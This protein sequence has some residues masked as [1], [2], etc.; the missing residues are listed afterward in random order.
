M[1]NRLDE[2]TWTWSKSKSK[3]EAE[4]AGSETDSPPHSRD[5]IKGVVICSWVLASVLSVNTLLTIIAAGIAYSKNN[6]SDFSFAS[7]YTGKCSVVKKWSTG[8]HLVINIL[9]T[10]MLGASNYCMQCL[11]SPSRAEVDEAHSKRI[12]VQI[13]VPNIWNLLRKQKGKRQLLGWTLLVTSLPIHLIYNSTVFFAFG[14]TEYTVVTAPRGP[15]TGNMSADFEECF[16]GLVQMDM[17]MFNAEMS[18]SDLEMLSNEDCIN[19]FAQDY[20]SGQRMVV[21]VTSAPMPDGEPVVFMEPGNAGSFLSKGGSPFQW[22]CGGDLDCTAEVAKE[23]VT[24]DVWTVQPVRWSIP[25]LYIQFPTPDGFHN[26]SGELY[27]TVPGV[28]DTPD[29]RRLSE[30]LREDPYEPELQAELDDPS[31]WVDPS[32]PGN[33]TIYGHKAMCGIRQYVPVKLPQT[34]PVDHCLTVPAEEKC[35]LVFSPPICIVVIGCNLIKLVCTLFTARDSREDVFLT[36][37]DAIASFLARPDPTTE[38]SCLLSKPLVDKKVQGWHKKP[39]KNKN[40]KCC[41]CCKSRKTKD[42]PI[43]S[44]LPLQLPSRKRWF[45]AVSTG[46]WIFTITVFICMLVPA[47]NL[48]R[49]G[50]LDYNR[51]YG[52]GKNIWDGGLGDATASTLLAGLQITPD[53]TGTFLAVLLAN[54]P[55]FLISIAYFLLNALLTIMLGAVEYDNYSRERKPLRVSWPRGAQRST[56]YLSLPYR[57]SFPLLIVSA[58]LHWLVSQSLFFVE[59]VPFDINGATNPDD[60]IV[61]C[62]YSPVAIIFAIVVGG[63]LPLA[64][65]LLGLR[66]FRSPMPLAAQCSAAISAAC[67]PTTSS[68]DDDSNHALKPIQWGEIPE[69]YASSGPLTFSNRISRDMDSASGNDDRRMMLPAD[70][71]QLS[72]YRE[73]EAG[74]YHCS[75][76]S[77][78]VCQPKRGRMYI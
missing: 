67:H 64:S 31:N 34:Y 70:I 65:M 51:G 69:P 10:V 13:G 36:I 3:T 23:T 58:V 8:L 12:W 78:D 50:I 71:E 2:K 35:Q 11:A 15:M 24:G 44:K 62:G 45:Q 53:T 68:T 1:F 60:E 76:T 49:L 55:Q 57:Y 42:I 22:M 16:E 48:L 72:A 54:V 66:R 30:L 4:I 61:T 28:P 33:V 52:T 47:I 9:S 74:V 14:P 73:V 29:T 25:S 20:V 39:K 38:G 40:R 41:K 59:I 21:L 43:Y 26:I 77:E 7:L 18:R 75:F 19:T 27:V 63:A 5:W 17:D 6:E 32:F 37:G 46:R 56:Y